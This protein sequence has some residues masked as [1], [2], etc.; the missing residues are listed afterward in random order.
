MI[1]ESWSRI[2][3]LPLTARPPAASGTSPVPRS[4][5]WR[6]G[7]AATRLVLLAAV[8]L[9][10][11]LRPTAAGAAAIAVDN[12]AVAIA[13]DGQCSLSE[14]IINANDGAIHADCAPGDPAGADTIVL[15]RAGL[16]TL[17]A[18]LGED[19]EGDRV[20]LP[21]VTTDVTIEGNY[22]AIRRP[23]T[24]EPFRLMAV[25]ETGRLMLLGTILGGGLTGAGDGAGIRSLGTLVVVDS[26]FRNNDSRFGL[27]GGAI[28]ADGAVTIMDSRFEDNSSSWGGA[29][30][31]GPS[32]RLFVSG[33]DFRSQDGSALS[34]A[35]EVEIV[36]SV[37]EGNAGAMDFSEAQVT[38][39]R[40][41]IEGNSGG[42]GIRGVDSTILVTDS[43]ISQNRAATGLEVLGGGG[44]WGLRSQIT[45]RRSTLNDNWAETNGGGVMVDGGELVLED[46]TVTG[47]EAAVFNSGGGGIASLNGARVTLVNITVA[48]NV[49]LGSGGGIWVSS[50][51]FVDPGPLTLTRT[52]VTGNAAPAGV[53]VHAIGADVAADNYNLFGADGQAGVAG[54]TPGPTDIVPAAGVTVDEIIAAALADNGGPTQTLSPTDGSPAIDAAPSADCAGRTDQRGAPRNADGDDSPSGSECDIGAVEFTGGPWRWEVRLPLVRR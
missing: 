10:L 30:S 3:V 42:G 6:P 34:S 26:T 36:D 28:A 52:I 21:M 23:A 33:S 1:D 53:Q 22:S 35:G 18:P 54:F 11:A 24:A 32:S 2:S 29:I 48:H 50:D 8:A 41:L 37:F 31:A 46:S 13:A 27:E 25:T 40:C 14:A 4:K 15:P 20:G 51:G 43:T 19:V 44:I 9:L 47:N 39:T 5:R 49:A 12:G 45:V 17:T 7:S 38:I 16:F